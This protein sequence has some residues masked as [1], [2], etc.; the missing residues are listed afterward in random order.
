MTAPRY[1]CI[2]GHFYQ[3][4]RENAW[5]EAIEAQDSARPYHDWNERI[6]AECYKPNSLARILDAEQRIARITN[7][8]ARISFDFG[9]TLLS[10]L[11]ARRPEVHAAIVAGDRLS[12]ELFEGHGSGL[13]Q[14]YNHTILP[15]AN[16]RDKETQVRWGLAD[17]ERRFGRRAE[18]MWLPETAA[19]IETLEVLAEHGLAFTVLAPRQAK[20]VRPL[21]GGPWTDV[22]GERV[23]PRQAYLQRLPSGRSIALFFYDGPVSRAVAFEG[24]LARG[25]SLAERLLGLLPEAPDGPRLAHIATDGESY[26]HH[27]RFGEMALAYALDVI[28][29]RPGVEL[30]SYGLFLERHPPEQEVEIVEGT[31]WSCVHG[32]ERWRSNCGCNS[33][34]GDGWTQQWRRPLRAALDGLRDELAPR[35]AERAGRLLRDPWAARDAYIQVLLDRSR[36]NVDRFLAEQ[37]ARP[38]GEAEAVEALELLE[39]QRNTQLMYTS[40]G[41]FFDEISGLETVQVLQYA[42]RAIQLARKLFGSDPEPEF[43]RVLARAPSNV[44]HADGAGVYRAHVQ[45]S[46]VTLAWVGAHFAVSSLFHAYAARD[47]IYCFQVEREV[48]RVLQQGNARLLA[49]RVRVTSDVTR[50]SARL[51][52]AVFHLGDHTIHGGVR[53]Y[54][55]AESHEALTGQL[56]QAFEAQD[57]PALVHL[58][59]EHFGASV[60]SLRSLFRDEQRR[61]LRIL[62]DRSLQ[63]EEAAYSQLYDRHAALMRLVADVGAPLP[64]AFRLT[65]EFVLNVRLR[66]AL[67]TDPLDAARLRALVEEARREGIELDVEALAFA[68]QTTLERRAA[69]LGAGPGDAAAWARLENDLRSARQVP[70]AYDLS[71]VQDRYW[72]LLQEHRPGRAAAAG[73]ADPAARAWLQRFDAVGALLNVRVE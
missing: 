49:G 31:S 56:A 52:Y 60:Y 1:I 3:P 9:P 67:E 22:T 63:E 33:G 41:W 61:V 57:T 48:E 34:R 18:G 72:T 5:L 59:D 8:Y 68:L 50:E 40:C 11:E 43:L 28:E 30:A 19:D 70:F 10:W 26:G 42:G 45:G 14:A 38:L 23:D 54:E 36:A 24:L 25:E 37:A 39:L 69:A 73:R 44:E 17:F 35:Y 47:R 16:R 62:V 12:R 6:A 66:R 53:P 64:R 51:A 20:R 32:V 27:H 46:E 58:V 55:D 7:N 15:L 29:R 2:H 13:A 65:A 71:T 21:A 4:P